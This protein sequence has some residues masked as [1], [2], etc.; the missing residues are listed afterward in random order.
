MDKVPNLGKLI[1]E[2][3]EKDAVHIAAAMVTA[4][5]ISAINPK[6]LTTSS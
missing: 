5:A 4:A 6:L 1:T 2:P 3:Q